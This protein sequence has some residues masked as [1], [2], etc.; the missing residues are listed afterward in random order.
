MKLYLYRT[1]ITFDTDELDDY[2]FNEFGSYIH[3]VGAIETKMEYAW[4]E[5]VEEYEADIQLLLRFIK[6]GY[7]LLEHI[8]EV[9]K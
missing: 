8:S 7:R 4:R 2:M 5:D 9:G 1:V 3:D 6:D